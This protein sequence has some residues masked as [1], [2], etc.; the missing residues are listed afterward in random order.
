MIIVPVK[1]GENIERALKK[2]FQILEADLEITLTPGKKYWC[3]WMHRYLWYKGRAYNGKDY[4][5]EDA[6][7]VLVTLGANEVN[8]LEEVKA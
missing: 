7:D 3:E 1:D 8:C 5:F 2:F 4:D 6:G